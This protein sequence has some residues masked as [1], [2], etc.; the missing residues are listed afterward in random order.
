MD[1]GKWKITCSEENFNSIRNDASFLE[2][3]RFARILNTIRFLQVAFAES[4]DDGTPSYKRFRT[5]TFLFTGAALYEAKKS[6]RRTDSPLNE[7]ETHEKLESFLNSDEMAEINPYIDKIRNRIVFHHD[8]TIASRALNSFIPPEY[9]FSEGYGK[10]SK[11]LYF[12]L[13]D[14]ISLHF[15]F[16]DKKGKVLEEEAIG[17]VI[18]QTVRLAMEFASIG[19]KLVGEVLLKNGWEIEGDPTGV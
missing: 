9:S 13:A 2:V 4:E 12:H 6:V 17:K 7:Y 19:E 8:P 15:L 16:M 11:Q 18:Q 5:N 3:V 10:S 14:H 1:K